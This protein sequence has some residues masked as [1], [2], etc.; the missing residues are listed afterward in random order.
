MASRVIRAVRVR[1]IPKQAHNLNHHLI[2]LGCKPILG[3]VVLRA[4]GFGGWGGFAVG[5]A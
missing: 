5:L 2:S 3:L 4:S 1:N